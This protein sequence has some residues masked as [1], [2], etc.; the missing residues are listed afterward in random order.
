MTPPKEF[1]QSPKLHGFTELCRTV[2][3]PAAGERTS[4]E[5]MK[6]ACLILFWFLLMANWIFAQDGSGA[7]RAADFS[8]A[9][10]NSHASLHGVVTK[11]PGSEPVKKVLIELIAE[12]QNDGGNYTASTDAEG[13]FHLEGIVPGRY[14]LFAER[15][16]YLE[17]DAHH[18]HTEGRVLTLRAGEEVKDLVIRLQPSA[19]VEGR[20]TDEDGDPMPNA[21]V[22][23]L[24]QSFASGRSHWE[25]AAGERTN[26]LG[27]YRIA[28]LAAG[29]YYVSVTPPPDLKNWIETASKDELRSRSNASSNKS[30]PTSY[31]TTYY[32][33]TRDRGEAAPIQLHAGDDFP[34]NFSLTRSPSLAIR[35]SVALPRGATGVVMAH[36]SDFGVMLSSADVRKDGSFEIRDVAPGSYAVVAAV[37]GPSISMMARQAVQVASADVDGLRLVPQRGETVRGRL[38]VESKS[39]VKGFDVGQIYLSLASAD[40]DAD[41]LSAISLGESFPSTMQV[42][43]EVLGAEPIR[44]GFSGITH[45]HADGSFEW[46][47]VP[48]GRY[49]VQLAGGGGGSDWFLKSV[50]AGNREIKDAGLT[51]SGGAVILDV[52]AGTEAAV[53]D[54]VVVNARGEPVANA[55]VVAVPELRLRSRIDRF[56]KTVSDQSGRFVLRGVTPGAYTL[57]AWESVDGDDYYN[58]DFLKTYEE[59]GKALSAGEGEHNSV[60]L[61]AASGAEEQP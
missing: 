44:E 50:V 32:P 10:K 3:A 30:P 34:A 18:R 46:N 43:V 4:N 52:T 41:L 20:V 2:C 27:E 24:R 19:I 26:D 36:S 59:Q 42:T 9:M 47:N 49:F 55:V 7:S 12:N 17:T 13:R 25:Q 58:P 53:V 40:G 61:K 33:G 29:T 15:T 8:D 31:T 38:R 54:G 11:D 39:G 51:V 37:T 56:R 16:G 14:H 22:A 57:L 28:G 35:G 5:P 23:V 60:Q 6:R 1:G 21:Q 45:V 48:P